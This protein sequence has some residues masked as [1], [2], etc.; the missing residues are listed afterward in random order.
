[1]SATG[2]L[3]AGPLLAPALPLANVRDRVVSCRSPA[4]RTFDNP[5]HQ[6]TRS[7]LSAGREVPHALQ[8]HRDDLHLLV[9]HIANLVGDDSDQ[10][11][12]A[13]ALSDGSSHYRY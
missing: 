11:V 5:L 12:A 10:D 4:R 3:A 2:A 1:M 6:I 9:R 8:S 13:I 7:Y